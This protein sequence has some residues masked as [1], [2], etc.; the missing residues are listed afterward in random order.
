MEAE[1]ESAVQRKRTVLVVEDNDMNRE[2]LCELLADDYHVLEA[3]NGLVGLEQLEEHHGEISVVLLDVYMPELDGFGFLERK[4]ADAR[5]DTI[6]VIMMTASNE[7][8]D[9][10]R[11]LE[12]GATDFVTKPYNVRVLKNRMRSVVRLRESNAMLGRLELDNLTGLY[13]KEFFHLYLRD[14][15]RDHPETH[16][17]LV[18]SDVENFRGMNDRWGQS[19]CD[20]FLRS[21]AERIRNELDGIVLG[22]RI[23]AD[24]FAFLVEHRGHDWAN[25]LP[26]P[27]REGSSALFTVKYGIYEDVDH[28]LTAAAVCDRATLPIAMIKQKFQKNVVLYDEDMRKM[29]QLEQEILDNMESSLK[30]REFQIYYQPKHDLHT[31]RTGGAEALVR[32]THPRLGFIRPDLF[33]PLFE[34]NGFITQ[35]DFYIW[36][37]VCRELRRLKELNLPRIPVSINASRMDFEVPDLAERIR[38]L[39]DKYEVDHAMLHVE[40]TESMYSDNPSQIA[41]TLEQLHEYGFI[42]ELDDFGAGYSSLT[43][44]NTLRLDVM[45]LDMSM[46]RH[47]SATHDYS[48]LRFAALLADGMRMKTVVEGVE[49]EK[50]VAAL[51]VLGC[52]YIQGYYYS[53]PIP[54]KEFEEYL[55]VHG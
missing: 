41:R 33:I 42:I 51:K 19:K 38:E 50:Q 28:S 21:L 7:I 22:G 40:L 4:Q 30:A 54:S 15:L 8:D 43:S 20:A 55:S 46:I 18:C 45:K 17:D 24:V 12:L 2:I 14:A 16:Y 27:A 29:Q 6:P 37:E 10:I 13:S 9:E 31:D 5:F 44:L 1:K 52:D 48:I 25:V 32:W 34:R 23:G 39:A 53:K 49:T 11:C 47:A 26:Q 36:E 35:L 3:E